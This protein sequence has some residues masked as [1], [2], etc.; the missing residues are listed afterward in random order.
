MG[1][2]VAASLVGSMFGKGIM[3]EFLK[4]SGFSPMGKQLFN[5]G[6]KAWGGGAASYLPV[7]GPISTAIKGISS[8]GWRRTSNMYRS[9]KDQGKVAAERALQ[10]EKM[11]LGDIKALGNRWYDYNSK[12][13]TK[14]KNEILPS[15]VRS[16]RSDPRQHDRDMSIAW[17]TFAKS[18]GLA[19]PLQLNS[20]RFNN[21]NSVREAAMMAED[22]KKLLVPYLTSNMAALGI[23]TLS[24]TV[25]T[26]SIMK[27]IN[28]RA[29]AKLNGRVENEYY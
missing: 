12:D 25:A 27:H 24:S 7:I 11:A 19:D 29:S 2:G 28:R 3:K 16:L 10:G 21:L 17:G 20:R 26:V 1:F 15:F 4:R 9:L 8:G 6:F 14:V 18:H 22:S 13:Y 23:P 5:E